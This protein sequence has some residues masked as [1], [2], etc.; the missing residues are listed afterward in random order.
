MICQVDD[1]WREGSRTAPRALAVMYSAAFAGPG[2]CIRGRHA[3]PHG[4]K[5]GKNPGLELG[6]LGDEVLWY[7]TV[8][9]QPSNELVDISYSF[10]CRLG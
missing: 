4:R 3:M 2:G 10:L 5:V 7:G 9:P 6:L 8:D 1:L